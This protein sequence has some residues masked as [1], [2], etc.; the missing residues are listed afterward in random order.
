MTLPFTMIKKLFPLIFYTSVILVVA[1]GIALVI[2]NQV[3]EKYAKSKVTNDISAI[4]PNNIALVLG[5][6]K[7]L[8]SGRTNDYFQYRMD[9]AVLLYRQGKAKHF[10]VSGDNHTEGYDE[11]EDMRQAL[12][13]AG[14]PDSCITLDYAGFRTLDSIIRCQKVFG[15]SSFIIVSQKFHNER[16]VFLAGKNGMDVYGFNAAEVGASYGF[17]T[18][19]REYFARVKACMDIYLL[20]TS[21]KFLG[22]Q[23]KLPL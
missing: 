16:A 18:M 4:P 9:A 12:I 1:G 19:V 10:I 7:T 17:R 14:I 13:A 22:E 8:K 3:I 21:P 23:V 5:T 6:V 15:Q 11:P 2:C 20:K